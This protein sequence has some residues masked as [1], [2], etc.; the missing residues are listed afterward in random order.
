MAGKYAKLKE[1]LPKF[2]L[3]VKYQDKIDA[4]KEEFG[5][6]QLTSSEL[7]AQFVEY[8]NAI[9]KLDEQLKNLHTIKEAIV[10]EL[11]TALEDDGVTSFRLATGVLIYQQEEPYSSVED[12]EVYLTWIRANGYEGLLNV[13]YQSTNSLVKTNLLGGEPLPPGIKVFMKTSIRYRRG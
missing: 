9:D 2:E 12:R 11:I 3:D 13:P 10:Q 7:G 5:L 1:S 4:A 8:Q 6:R